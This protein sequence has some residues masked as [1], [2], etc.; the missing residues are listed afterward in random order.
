MVKLLLSLIG[1][2][3]FAAFAIPCDC[4]VRVHT[5]LTGSHR[6]EPVIIKTYTLE[7]FSSMAP[8]N[9]RACRQ[10]CLAEFHS[11]MPAARLNALLV[12]YS[13]QL[14]DQKVLGY[15]CTGLTNL[16]YP[17]R[18]KARLAQSGLGNVADL[19]QVISHEEV[20]F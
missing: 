14:I 2:W 9:I 19:V 20:C 13:M 5:P 3:S 12:T 18:V 17:V 1:F 8:K 4:E 11:D 6:M 10:S 16:K 7:E 15:N